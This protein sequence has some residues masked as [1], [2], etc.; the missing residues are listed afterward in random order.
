MIIFIL[1]VTKLV[2]TVGKFISDCLRNSV[3]RC[4]FYTSTN[5]SGILSANPSLRFNFRPELLIGSWNF[6]TKTSSV[7]ELSKNNFYCNLLFSG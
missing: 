6:F 3:I 5:L 7:L 1:V 2:L 4:I